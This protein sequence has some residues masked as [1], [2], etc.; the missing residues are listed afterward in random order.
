MKISFFL[1]LAILASGFTAMPLFTF[2]Q[3]PIPVGQEVIYT[4][5]ETDPPHMAGTVVKIA[6]FSAR[7]LK[8]PAVTGKDKKKGTVA[9]A[10]IIDKKG[11]LTKPL[12]TERLGK[13]Y[14]DEALRVIN[15]MQNQKLEPGTVNGEPVSVLITVPFKFPVKN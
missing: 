12:I 13:A 10:F 3:E 15:L 9:V 6:A 4:L 11:Q 14:D 8:D 1:L 5:R 2:A 7:K